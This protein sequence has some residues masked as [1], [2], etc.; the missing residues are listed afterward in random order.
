MGTKQDDILEAIF[1]ALSSATEGTYYFISNLKKKRSRW[2]KEAVEFFGLPGEFIDEA[3]EIWGDY[4]HPEDRESFKKDVESCIKGEKDIHIMTYRVKTKS[5]KYVE[6]TCNAKVIRDDDGN[7]LYLAGSI[8]SHGAQSSIDRITGL[9]NL[10]GFFNDMKRKRQR[11]QS[12]IVLLTG[13]SKFAEIND[14]YGYTFGNLVL[15]ELA[16]FLTDKFS[17]YT[18]VYRMEGTKFAVVTEAMTLEEM[19]K[20][21]LELQQEVSRHLRVNDCRVNILLSGG[22]FSFDDFTVKAHTVYSCLKYAYYESRDLK[23]GELV[24]FD[25]QVS[26]EDRKSMR[27]ISAIREDIVDGC[28]DFYM[29]YQPVMDA[30]K[31][32]LIGLESLV[33]WQNDKY[34]KVEPGVFIP[35]LET[36]TNFY[37]LGNWILRQ[38]MLEVKPLLQVYP[39]LQLNI[40]LSYAQ[41]EKSEFLTKLFEIMEEVEFPAENLCLEL[42]ERCRLLD[43]KLVK[44]ITTVLKGE[45]IKIALDD[46]GTGFSS[47]EI[48]NA[49]PDIDIIKVDRTFVKDIDKSE[50]YQAIVEGITNTANKLHRKVCIEGVETEQMKTVLQKYS[51]AS[52]QG[53]LYSKP[54]PIKELKEWITDE[55]KS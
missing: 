54:I 27:I 29:C 45:G 23:Q 36:D 11:E 46:F 3:G 55:K 47:M 18:T 1:Y 21:Y 22:L 9:R 52:F 39:D 30:Q 32:R 35:I 13:I 17:S 44:Q 7:P 48:I 41:L 20:A 5:G 2:S 49:V 43:M 37:Q 38:S 6:C 4:V 15:K 26:L 19:Q 33:R 14:M 12:C 24:I 28:K 53:Y 40:N 8:I 50:I 51:P 42:T 16:K 31:E 10:Y 25:N 34:G